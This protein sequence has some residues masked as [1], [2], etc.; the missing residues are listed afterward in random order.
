M[1]GN[2]RSI[3]LRGYD[4]SRAG[5]YFVTVCA[6][7]RECVFGDVVSGRM[8]LNNSGRMVE[9]CW[10][11][12][13]VHFPHVKSDEFIVMPNHVHGILLIVGAR[14]AVPLPEQFGKPVSSSI[15]TVVRSFKSAATKQI[16]QTR[17]NPGAKLW[18]RNYYEHIIREDDELNRI[19]EYMISNPAQWE[20]DPENPSGVI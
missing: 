14:H 16:N 8:V 12:I 2:R 3:R 17:N 15:P 1:K 20:S 18:Q 9:K 10:N 13:P 11:D 6:Q 19:R 7:E 4:Y 5:A